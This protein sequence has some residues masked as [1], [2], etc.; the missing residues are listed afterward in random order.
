V[1][2][3]GGTL[4]LDEVGE[5]SLYGQAKLLRVLETKL[6]EPLGGLARTPLDVRFL[7][8]TNRSLEDLLKT[9]SFRSDLYYRLAVTRVQLPSLRQRVEDIPDLLDTFL[10]DVNRHSGRSIESFDNEALE[11]L[12]RH[13]WPGNVRE[14]K[15]LVDAI[16]VEK[17]SGTVSIGDLPDWFTAPLRVTNLPVDERASLVAALEGARWNKSRAAGHL[18][19]SRMKLYRKLQ[20]HGLQSSASGNGASSQRRPVQSSHEPQGTEPAQAAARRVAS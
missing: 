5:L 2:A 20:R 19:W 7:S 11:M 14:L 15:N 16:A 4:F 9:G 12:L 17:L 1:E 13:N 18:G 3:D 8:A 10:R 6:V